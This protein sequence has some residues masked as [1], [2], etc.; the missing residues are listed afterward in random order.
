[1]PTDAT[2][3]VALWL[4]FMSAGLSLTALFGLPAART[5]ANPVQGRRTGLSECAPPFGQT[6]RRAKRTLDRAPP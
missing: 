2:T 4:A 5:W 1:M 6:E 3:F